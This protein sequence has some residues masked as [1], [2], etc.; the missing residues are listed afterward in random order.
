MR[1]QEIKKDIYWV[2]ARDWSIR[3]FH[4]YEVARGTS[5]NS[6]LIMD[7]KITLVDTVKEPFTNELIDRIKDIVD[8]SK[9]DY[10][11]CNHVEM[12]HSG[13]MPE[14]MNLAPNATIITDIQ[15]Q[16]ALEQHYEIK[17]W[18]I[19]VVKTGDTLNIGQRTLSFVQ[20]PMLHWPDSMVTYVAEDKL[21]LPNDGFGQHIATENLF[22]R[23]NS[24]D[25]I[26][27]EA[28]KY[29]AN[30][31]FPFPKQ[32]E[33]ALG[34]VG[35]LEIDMIAPSHGCIWQGEEEIAKITSLYEKWAHHE[36]NGSAV[37]IYDTMWKSTEKLA[38]A[39]KQELEANGI[40]TRFKSLQSNHISDVI[41]DV[42][43][44]KY[45]IIGSPTLNKEI[46]PTVAGFMTY[47]KGLAP[48]NKVGFAFGSYG[49]AP[50]A[51]A[52]VQGV[53]EHL[54]WEVPAEPYYVKYVPKGNHTEEI[55]EKIRELI[56]C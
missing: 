18:K 3:N 13:A 1:A 15:G 53:F 37:I 40:K 32:A 36:N 42:M 46:L 47:M 25:I 10:L 54:K 12:D 38:E 17:D 52:D 28:K 8:P 41:V 56:K 30:I 39:I 5:Y 51:I 45:V 19:E 50:T 26:Y 4:G 48:K 35:E 43:D 23:D 7:E 11:V 2:G 9:I 49:W 14:I 29:Y 34:A 27:E 21:L 6:Y 24:I 33:K 44:A 16:M 55:K 31:L 22:A 20:T